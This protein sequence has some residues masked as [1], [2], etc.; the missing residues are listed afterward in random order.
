MLIGKDGLDKLLL[1]DLAHGVA[2]DA[3]DHLHDLRDLVVGEAALEGAAHL[4][5]GP[6]LRDGAVEHDDGADLVAPGAAG[7]GDDG[8][9]GDLRQGEELALDLEGADLFAAR[10]D[11]VGGLAALDEVQGALGPGLGGGVEACCRD[12][13]A[14]GDVAR[15][16]PGA[17][18]VRVGSR[19][20]L[21]GGGWVA[22]VLLEDGGTAELDL[23]GA[24]AAL[25]VEFLTGKDY[26]CGVDVD[27]AGLDGR[28]GPA[29][30]SVDAVSEG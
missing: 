29:D 4:Q 16:E 11:D 6:L 21:F 17:V 2:R 15:F 18:A 19:K 7:H 14:D 12:G 30:R 23:A 27:E 5:G 26:F 24:L 9:L 13:A 22:P 20:L 8:G 3:L 28:K 25:G 1:V 10:L